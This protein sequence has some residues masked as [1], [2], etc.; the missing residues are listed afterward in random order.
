MNRNRLRALGALLGALL[1]AVLPLNAALAEGKTGEGELRERASAYWQARIDR[2]ESVIE[3]YAPE[4]RA[5]A[6]DEG[7]MIFSEFALEGVE[8]LDGDTAVVQ[9]RVHVNFALPSQFH[10][11][12][13]DRIFHPLISERWDRVAGVWYKR[14]VR[15]GLARFMSSTSEPS[16]PSQPSQPSDRQEA[17]P[18]AGI[19][20]TN[21]NQGTEEEPNG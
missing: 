18:P 7:N 20:T 11:R 10:N 19:A 15:G 21:P 9:V 12:L 14:P 16:E 8:L 4:E 3:F 17:E 1:T 13:P 5:T 6:R 2:S